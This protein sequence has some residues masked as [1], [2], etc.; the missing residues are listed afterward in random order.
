M[1]ALYDEI[2]IFQETHILP[3]AIVTLKNYT[4]PPTMVKPV[5]SAAPATTTTTS[6]TQSPSTW[7]VDAVAGWISSLTLSKEYLLI[8]EIVE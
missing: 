6:T 2:V 8:R 1:K 7:T 3:H 4:A 5:V